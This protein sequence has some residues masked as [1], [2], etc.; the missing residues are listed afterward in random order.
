MTKTRADGAS[1]PDWAF[2]ADDEAVLRA[3]ETGEHE[4]S[5]REFFGSEEYSELGALAVRASQAR[6]MRRRNREGRAPQKVLIL[7]GIM[8]SKLGRPKSA[9]GGSKTIWVDPLRIAAG[10]LTQLTLPRGAGFKPVGV[11]LFT[12]AKLKLMLDIAGFDARFHAYDWRLGINESGAKLAARIAR[13][14][15]PVVLVA[16]SMG[17]LVARAALPL[18]RKASVRRL[19]MV[20]TPNAGTYAAA[21]A[22]CGTY[23]TV[24]KIAMLDLA[25]SAEELAKRVF[26]S[27]AGLYELLP[28]PAADA[29]LDIYDPRMWPR[30]Q[31]DIDPALLSAAKASR[32]GLAAA[33]SRFRQIIGVDQPTVAAIR[34]QA[35]GFAYDQT[36]AGDGTVPIASARL[37]GARA[38]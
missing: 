14:S 21:Q 22:L 9:Q 20:G 25:H 6:A 17:G 37:P 4:Q 27:F 11:M 18:L 2:H 36:L 5:L 32:A 19:I 33:D 7:P 8:G 28:L 26:R 23:P 1:E 10:Q 16:H 29:P 30:S 15:E 38:F 24:R 13:E 3:L 34:R 35:G 12:Y 31:S